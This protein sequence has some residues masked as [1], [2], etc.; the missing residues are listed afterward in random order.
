MTLTLS[1][2]LHPRLRWLCLS[3]LLLGSIVAAQPAPVHA[4]IRAPIGNAT[5]SA[6]APVL[7][8]WIQT[9]DVAHVLLLTDGR[10]EK[11]GRPAQF[12]A[13]AVLDFTGESAFQHWQRHDASAL[14]PGLTVR[15]AEVLAQGGVSPRD[16]EPTVFVVNTYT[17]LVPAAEFAEYVRGYVQPLYTAM[18]ASGHLAHYTAYLE[19]GEP[20]KVNAFNVLEYRDARAL[21]AMRAAKA[22]IRAQV[23]ATT[24]SYVHFGGIKDTLRLD[25]FGTLA[26]GTDLPSPVTRSMVRIPS[27]HK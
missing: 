18:H 27:D 26:T 21:A 10:P 11:A 1:S 9:G 5:A 2:R 13:M 8:R 14:P 15:R 3:A 25:G 12:G 4:I 17:P 22:G 7:A 20:G 16:L 6:L 24:P 19:Q 23:A